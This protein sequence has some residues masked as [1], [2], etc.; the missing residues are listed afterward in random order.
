M[1]I[2]T[3]IFTSDLL[4]IEGDIAQTFSY[5]GAAD[6]PCVAGELVR[7][8]RLEMGGVYAEVDQILVV[9]AAVL[10]AGVPAPGA[11]VTHG[12]RTLRVLRVGAC[13]DGVS[14]NLYLADSK[15]G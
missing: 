3:S 1:A 12:G 14:Y 4:S 6:V 10:T 9:R 13:P 7:G 15:R 8:Q 2:D 5:A 11:V